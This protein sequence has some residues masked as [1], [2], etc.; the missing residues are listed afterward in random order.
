MKV[1]TRRG[2]RGFSLTELLLVIGLIAILLAVAVP[3]VIYYQRELKLTELDD[4]ARAVFV[5]AQ[6]HL[7]ALRSASA[8]EL[9]VGA[10]TDREALT[11][12]AGATEA[13]TELMYV[14]TD[15]T[16]A[17][18]GWLVLP[19]SI[20]ADLA[21]GC[22]LVEFE[23]KSGSV[24]GVFFMERGGK[25]LDESTYKT[26]YQ[27]ADG[28][29][30]CRTRDG[31]KAF[32][33]SGGGFYVGYYGSNGAL[34]MTRPNEQTLPKPKLTLTNAEELR[35]EIEAESWPTGIDQDKVYASVSVS[36][37]AAA[38]VLVTEGAIRSGT[39][40]AVVLDTLK[41]SGYNTNASQPTAGW[42]VGAPFAKWMEK[43]GSYVITPGKNIT[44]TV[45]VFYKP[46][47]GEGVVALPQSASVSVNSLF[48]A[49]AGSAVQVGYG[50]HLQNLNTATSHL[51]ETVTA[52]TQIRSIDFAKVGGGLRSWADTYGQ[53]TLPFVPIDNE[54][55]SSYNGG[56]MA[57]QN[58]FAVKN[59]TGS[60]QYENAGLFGTFR[61][62]QLVDVTLVDARV[63][64]GQCGGTLAGVLDGTA[65]G[66]VTVSGC[67]VYMTDYR[68][69]PPLAWGGRYAGGLVGQAKN[70]TIQDGSFAATTVYGSS[71]GASTV[72]GLV[73]HSNG[74]LTI[75]NSYAAGHL[76]GGDTGSVVGGL[77][78]DGNGVTI[79]DSYAAGTIAKATSAAG[80]LSAGGANVYRSYAAVDYV[81]VPTDGKV[82]GAV[83]WGNCANASYLTKP[84]VNYAAA[85]VAN[86]TA[87]SG[88]E[89]MATRAALGL[90]SQFGDGA[91]SGVEATP[92]NLPNLAKLADGSTPPREPQ[93]AKPYPYPTLKTGTAPNQESVPHYGDWLFAEGSVGSLIAYYEQ[94]DGRTEYSCFVS[95]VEKGQ[96]K[97]STRTGA[98]NADGYAFLSEQRFGED[99]EGKT[100][101]TVKTVGMETKETTV[102]GRFLGTL[103]EDLKETGTESEIAYYA[104]ALPTVAL[105]V[106][107]NGGCYNEVT[108]KG[109]TGN[110]WDTNR[111]EVEVTAWVTTLFGRAAYNGAKPAS[112]PDPIHIRSLRHLANIGRFF[113]A[114]NYVQ[115]LDID[116]SIYYG[117]LASAPK[118]NS[119][120]SESRVV[121]AAN[122]VT[123]A[124]FEV[125]GRGW[126]KNWNYVTDIWSLPSDYRLIFSPVGVHESPEGG[127][128]ATVTPFGGY[129]DGQG[130]S[131][132]ALSLRPY[133]HPGDKVNYTG[134]FY[135]ISGTVEN[136]RLI[137]CDA[138]GQTGSGEGNS[139]GILAGRVNSGGQVQGCSVTDCAVSVESSGNGGHVGGMI[140]YADNGA[141]TVLNCTVKNCVVAG[142]DKSF[143][144]G[145]FVGHINKL[146]PNK[147]TGSG[148]VFQNCVVRDVQVSNGFN[149][150]DDVKNITKV[151]SLG[152]FVGCLSDSTGR[153]ENCYVIGEGE[154]SFSGSVRSAGG[155][156]GIISNKDAGFLAQNCG[157]RLENPGR[158]GYSDQPVSGGKTSGGFVG[159][160][161]GKG[162]VVS[163]YAAVKVDGV[164]AGGF[165]GTLEGGSVSNC[166]AGG[167]TR[168]GKYSA[169]RPNVTGAAEGYVGGFAGLWTGGTVD[170][171]YTTCAVSGTKDETTDV[172]ANQG[173]ATEKSSVSG[174]YALG[175]AFVSGSKKGSLTKTKAAVTMPELAEDVRTQ[176][177]A[178]DS[179]LTMKY[180]YAP[181]KGTD[182]APM[183][184]Y[185]D[186]PYTVSHGTG[187]EWTPTPQAPEP[188]DLQ[189]LRSIEA[190]WTEEG[191]KLTIDTKGSGTNLAN[192]F[193]STGGTFSVTSDLGEVLNLL[194]ESTG[195]G[196][197][198]RVT[199]SMGDVWEITPMVIGNDAN[200][201]PIRSYEFTIPNESLPPYL[202]T[203][204]LGGFKQGDMIEEI[205]YQGTADG[206]HPIEA[207]KPGDEVVVDGIFDDWTG[208]PHQILNHNSGEGSSSVTTNKGAAFGDGNMIYL[209]LHVARKANLVP[210]P[211]NP[212]DLRNVPVCNMSC[213]LTDVNGKQAIIY[214]AFNGDDNTSNYTGPGFYSWYVG[215][216]ALDGKEVQA[217]GGGTA[218]IRVNEDGTQDMEMIID[219]EK[220]FGE[221]TA[222]TVV[223]FRADFGT[224]GGSL[225]IWRDPPSDL[226][227]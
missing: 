25:V 16:G 15:V 51:D 154:L 197:T 113:G 96:I 128:Y 175:T 139:T 134:L 83:Q 148:G 73:G 1:H 123:I 137:E 77:V 151:G 121:N 13:G 205:K 147:G 56:G 91:D 160:L 97:D 101:L 170:T 181:V 195:V 119:P 39:K 202:K 103:D 150:K 48:A 105:D 40:S 173:T 179:T 225:T 208:Y 49:R 41:T 127:T 71:L 17:E 157:V 20:E 155:F 168:S 132:R 204:D 206:F 107:P 203:L 141:V 88:T 217:P 22:Y 174:C 176:T 70:V 42:T 35:L 30:T 220:I 37:G 89:E 19:G 33:S 7:T 221:A 171:C 44:V 58:L 47:A 198:V 12:P 108:V 46:G 100:D 106:V 219:M 143:N 223:N 98:V 194:A 129:Y 66:G 210:D 136:V 2:R 8:G 191:L 193:N 29:K 90:G 152:G 145:G 112:A 24:Y 28:G 183:P 192:L 27:Y 126:D 142:G 116:A 94:F 14:S 118:G 109:M 156:A 82:Y 34:D 3:S 60:D 226:E 76:T 5:A 78:G 79:Q 122:H 43:G 6:N 95:G 67:R 87:F 63:K 164:T 120:I 4:N 124:G 61:G 182:G 10:T 74:G 190:H 68:V 218:Y 200:G 115:D 31:R 114:R 104:Y 32:L 158:N 85:A 153:L 65:G 72:G 167:N 216:Q 214:G 161:S 53:E 189:G 130:R 92:Y 62:S 69:D 180:P 21:E 222:M 133:Y 184:H 201:Q 215:G 188:A 224:L 102:R 131:I 166:Y 80:G 178:Y 162:S 9:K 54:K 165:V 81:D 196:S 207:F 212:G 135:R 84:G 169:G 38:K 57:I 163:C 75:Q 177:Y 11:V 110:S 144:V 209:R 140:G 45:S 146:I 211:S 186:W 55:L 86:V 172:F 213:I 93:L 111:E 149:G 26:I 187:F 59:K 36:D 159:T 125:W 117:D 23:P 50:R 199:D 18:P 138:I 227:A 52:A 185:G 99:W 64:G